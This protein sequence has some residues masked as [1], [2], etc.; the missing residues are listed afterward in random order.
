MGKLPR[1]TQERK[2]M[3]AFWTRDLKGFSP[4]DPAQPCSSFLLLGF[5]FLWIIYASLSCIFFREGAIWAQNAQRET[6]QKEK[7]K[8]G[9]GKIS[10]S[11]EEKAL[12]EKSPLRELDESVA[13][14][15]GL[16]TGTL[17]VRFQEGR[18]ERYKYKFHLYSKAKNRLYYFFDASSR[19][20]YKVLYFQYPESRLMILTWD[21]LRRILQRKER[22]ARFHRVLQSG[23]SYWDLSFLA[24]SSYYR[25]LS[26]TQPEA[27]QNNTS[28][29]NKRGSFFLKQDKKQSLPVQENFPE[30]II[31]YPKNLLSYILKPNVLS[32]YT[33]VKAAIQKEK[34]RAARLDFYTPPGL[35]RKSLY[36][37]YSNPFYDEAKKKEIHFR[38]IPSAIHSLDFERETLSSME[39]KSYESRASLKAGIFDPRF[40]KD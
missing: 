27:F 17:R 31:Q 14:P 4:R 22:E 3:K 36:F 21:P 5:L 13:Y 38:N 33:K 7:K 30:D 15:R 8:Q 32:P 6:I 2:S 24:Y 1:K 18:K 12:I 39:I 25:V 29:Q 19:L 26:K 11:R 37:S 16:Y 35:L 34:K 9:K 20:V 23:L 10:I 40:I 28:R